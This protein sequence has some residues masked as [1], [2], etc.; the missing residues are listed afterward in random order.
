MKMR[1]RWKRNA[2]PSGEKR[3]KIRRMTRKRGNYLARR[4][5]KGR[6][7][8]RMIVNNW[9]SLVTPLILNDCRM[10]GGWGKECCEQQSGGEL[11][12]DLPNTGRKTFSR[13]P[14]NWSMFL[15]YQYLFLFSNW[16]GDWFIIAPRNLRSQ[17]QI[18]SFVEF[19]LFRFG[20]RFRSSVFST[21]YFNPKFGLT[22]IPNFC[23][24]ITIH[25]STGLEFDIRTRLRLK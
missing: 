1:R 8:S 3:E 18:L 2:A 15:P 23:K 19:P 6:A 12:M 16:F 5:S 7:P 13:S 22:Q 17:M 20:T 14:P 24:V 21:S 10:R 4:P 9:F 25:T 11:R